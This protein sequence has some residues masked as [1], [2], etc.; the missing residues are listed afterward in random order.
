M[1]VKPVDGKPS[2][3]MLGGLLRNPGVTLKG[4]PESVDCV[5]LPRGCNTRFTTLLNT[6]V[7]NGSVYSSSVESVPL[8]PTG[9]MI[10][11]SLVADGL[12]ELVLMGKSTIFLES[13][14]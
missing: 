13:S 2:P 6:R 14:R 1:V 5:I 12:T 3:I 8:L 11:S 10:D 7:S 9:S 4:V